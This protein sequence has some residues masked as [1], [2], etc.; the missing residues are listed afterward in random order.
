MLSLDASMNMVRAA[1]AAD[2]R[3]PAVVGDA[4][5]LPLV[6]GCCD[7]VIAYMSLH[8]MTDMQRAVKE[9]TRALVPGGHLCMSVVHPINSAGQ[10]AGAEADS[11]FVIKGSYLESHPYVDTVDRDG[12]VM[13]FTSL[14]HPLEGYFRALEYVGLLVEAVREIAAD[15]ASVR[16][17]PRRHRW[18]RLPLFL[19]VRAVKPRRA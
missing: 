8:D 14:H 11:E 3:I 1:F 16:D 9:A 19:A 4:A 2:P 13:T 12:M 5:A 10:F 7:L 18:R 15:E 6:D 17:A